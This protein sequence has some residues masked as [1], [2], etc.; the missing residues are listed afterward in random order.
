MNSH[1]VDDVF[2][3]VNPLSQALDRVIG[4]HRHDSLYDQRAPIEFLGD[5]MDTAPMLGIPCFQGASMGVQ[6]FVARQQRRMDV[7]QATLVVAHEA[8]T[9]DTHETR[10]HHQVRG[11]PIET[12]HQGRIEGFAAFE[13]G[14]TAPMRTALSGMALL[15]ISACRLLPEPDSSTTTLQGLL[16]ISVP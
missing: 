5:E 3:C 16:G 7:E 14:M 4:C 10:Q 8:A 12:R 1:W 11:E 9:E 2:L 6:P 15:S 13:F